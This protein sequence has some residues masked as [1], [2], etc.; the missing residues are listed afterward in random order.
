MSAFDKRL[1]HQGVIIDAHSETLGGHEDIPVVEDKGPNEQNQEDTASRP[2]NNTES[3]VAPS[4]R[5]PMFKTNIPAY[6][7]HQPFRLWSTL[8]KEINHKSG[9]TK[10]QQ[11]HHLANMRQKCGEKIV[12]SGS[13]FQKEVVRLR[14]PL[15]EDMKVKMSINALYG[16]CVT[17][18]Q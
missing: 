8:V 14:T 15:D 4:G 9:W 10:G 5:T 3:A 12:Y 17:T 16:K 11:L 7:F 2:L 1:Q 6:H 18:R 13:E